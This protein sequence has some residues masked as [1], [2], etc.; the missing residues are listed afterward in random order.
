MSF[1]RLLHL[2]VDRSRCIFQNRCA[3]GK[4][5]PFR[6]TVTVRAFQP[7]P[8]CKLVGD[9]LVPGADDVD[10]EMSVAL[11]HGPCR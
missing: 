5:R 8:P 7:A 4:E 1:Q 10:T 9:G 6:P 11:D 2:A 3:A